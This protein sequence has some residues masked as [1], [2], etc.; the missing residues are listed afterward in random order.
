MRRY[1]NK[2]GGSNKP[3]ERVWGFS[4]KSLDST[5][6]KDRELNSARE[7]VSAAADSALFERLIEDADALLGDGLIDVYNMT[8]ARLELELQANTN[9]TSRAGIR[10]VLAP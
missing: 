9:K 5:A 10:V 3:K 2:K 1:G 7:V 4:K 8:G 6:V